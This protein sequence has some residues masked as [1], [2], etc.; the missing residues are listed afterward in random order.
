[1]VDEMKQAPGLPASKGELLDRIQREWDAL[2]RAVGAVT[3]EGMQVRDSGGW[4]VK[5]NL[6]H[7]ADWER[8]L[9]LCHLQGRPPYEVLGID[10]DT[11]RGLDED[12][13]NAILFERNKDRSLNDILEGLRAGHAQVLR[14]L[15]GIPFSQMT[16]QAY[17]DD[18]LARPLLAWIAGNTYEHYREHRA[19][20][21]DLVSR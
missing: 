4:G 20:I 11:Y 7:L 9:R 16:E 15:E 12:G 17:P 3:A 10:R 21:E 19:A 18:E 8:Y 6:A 2:E 14:D 1:M 5:D 13:E